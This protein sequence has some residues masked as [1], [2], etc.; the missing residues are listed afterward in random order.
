MNI[1]Y[2]VLTIVAA[3]GQNPNIINHDFL[4]SK[5]II[6]EAT[7]PP[8]SIITPPVSQL[9]YEN[10]RI[11]VEQARFVIDQKLTKDTGLF[12]SQ[13]IKRYYEVLPYTPMS[14]FGVNLSGEVTWESEKEYFNFRDS[15]F[16]KGDLLR[17]AT[18]TSNWLM[19]YSLK[20]NNSPYITTLTIDP[21]SSDWKCRIKT[22]SHRGL[23]EN[24]MDIFLKEI[25]EIE[26]LLNSV[27]EVFSAFLNGGK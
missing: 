4:V 20:Y 22:N 27:K 7:D 24:Q 10:F 21:P 25:C 2:S 8:V 6:A 19:G 14:A 16:G 12:A 18:S 9:T 5:S 11:T 15:S 23:D 13:Y 17:S 3:G 1:E 26:T